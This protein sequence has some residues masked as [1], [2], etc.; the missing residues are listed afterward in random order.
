MRQVKVNVGLLAVVLGVS[1]VVGVGAIFLNA[2]Q[3]RANA[4]V[5]K[6]LA[7]AARQEAEEAAADD[8]LQTAYAKYREAMGNLQSYL[9]LRRDDLDVREELGLLAASVMHDRTTFNVAFD[10]LGEVVRQDPGRR[11]ARRA[12]VGLLLRARR[13]SDARGH[14]ENHLLKSSPNDAELL[15]LLGICLTETGEHEKAAETFEK[16]VG[17]DP[18]RLS[19]YPRLAV[20]HRRELRRDQEAD[21]WMQK[22][23]EANPD[24]ADAH[25]ILGNYLRESGEADQAL[26]HAMK[27]LELE[28]DDADALLL[29]AQCAAALGTRLAAEGKPDEAEG[30]YAVARQY[31]QQGLKLQPKS[32]PLYLAAVDVESRAGRRRE[33]LAL[34]E[35]ARKQVGDHLQLLWSTGN[36]LIDEQRIDEA[37]KILETLRANPGAQARP[38]RLYLEARI[39]LAEGR[40]KVAVDGFAQARGPLRAWPDLVKQ[41]DLWTGQCY[42]ALGNP[43][44]AVR[45]Y[46][47]A[48]DVDRNY[49]P[50]RLA[51]IGALERQGSFREAL[52][53]YRFLAAQRGGASPLAMT[54]LLLLRTLREEPARRD[55]ATVERA[56]E[57]AEKFAP[58]AVEVSL[59]RAEVLSARGR[60]EEAETVFREARERHPDAQGL[61][62]ASVQLAIRMRD[63]DAAEALLEEAS[64]RFGDGVDHRLARARLALFRDGDQAAAEVLAL[65]RDDLDAFSQADRI[66]LWNGVLPVLVQLGDRKD[67][68]EFCRKIAEVEP[69]NVQVR[70]TLFELGLADNDPEKSK[71]ALEE[72]RR[73]EG[74]GPLWHYGEAVRLMRQATGGGNEALLDEAMRRLGRAREMRPNWGR[75]P[76]MMAGI[77]DERGN[78]DAALER[79]HE[80][81]RLGERNPGAILRASELLT[82]QGRTAEARDLSRLLAGRET[83]LSDR[84]DRIE[85]ENL[86]RERELDKALDLSERLAAESENYRD[87]IQYALLV[88]GKAQQEAAAGRGDEAQQLIG[89]AE[90]AHRKAVELAPEVP[91]TWLQLVQFLA[92]TR[93]TDKIPLAMSE[94]AAKVPSDKA[95][96]TTAQL[97]TVV[98]NREAA[99]AGFDRALAAA[100]NDAV[101][102]RAVA[103]FYQQVGEL[104]TAETQLMRIANREIPAE[105]GDIVWAKRRLAEIY[106]ARGTYQDLR[107]ALA[108]VEENIATFDSPPVEDL[109]VKAGILASMPSPR[110]R[111]RGIEAF[112]QLIERQVATPLDEFNLARVYLRQGEYAKFLAR[113]RFLLAAHP[114]E[115]QY[116]TFYIAALLDRG[117][118]H[119]ARLYLDQL[120]KIAPDQLSTVGLRAEVL[121]RQERYEEASETLKSFLDNEN[122]QPADPVARLGMIADALDKLSRRLKD[123]QEHA[124]A[125]RVAR[126]ALTLYQRYFDQTPGDQL[127]MAALLCRQGD[128]DGALALL[129]AKWRESQPQ[130]I[131]ETIVVMLRE[132]K[133]GAHQRQRAEDVLIAALR[134]F[135]RPHLLLMALADFYTVEERYKE[136]ERLYREILERNS[137]HAVAMNNLAVLLGHQKRNLDEALQLINR[138]IAIAGPVGA[139]LDSRATVYMALGQPQ[140]ALEDLEIA[141][142]DDPSPIRLFHQAQ[143]YEQAGRTAE[144]R[145]A[146]KKANAAGLTAEMLQRPELPVY[147]MLQKLLQ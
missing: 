69:N 57:Q 134:Q 12:L 47:R 114:R 99:K 38:L 67:A 129:E 74:E 110:D 4:D 77:H 95:A 141:V 65:A 55:W 146:L 13:Y 102:V 43:E 84:F 52:E 51:L 7:D 128:V 10:A 81:I 106:G 145:E 76:M 139:M 72:I 40:W 31:A 105:S 73:I 14:L 111:Q 124:L 44:Q 70:F 109:R 132:G 9:Q 19:L 11:E 90:S 34:L 116:L 36:L 28:P 8:D 68:E 82:R 79:Y 62:L 63:W 108:M 22:L 41:T 21:A 120:E 140:K 2:Y 122:A 6:E 78:T 37:G 88:T 42:E 18:G 66:R 112:E 104:T 130:S 27:A 107:K 85:L 29:A 96:L 89:L 46:R 49:V 54:R 97:H 60:P 24:S 144:A 103:Q 58:G 136:A 126:D 33:G 98:G 50:A 118:L 71:L 101:V 64:E 15:E 35:E 87:Q 113:M 25:R 16:A 3:K 5:F 23:I 142:S 83:P 127:R 135:D 131:A 59:L 115:P 20:V 143:A 100:P 26:G 39:A 117:E 123:K 45:A 137:M 48:L 94:A 119:N 80:A 61:W 56:L 75:V 121:F 32:V 92:R 53:Q 125:T 30:Q 91:E 86:I 1:L 138:A 17:L 147:A 133:A 93:Q